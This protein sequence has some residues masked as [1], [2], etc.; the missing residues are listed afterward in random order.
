MMISAST[1]LCDPGCDVEPAVTDLPSDSLVRRHGYGRVAVVRVRGRSVVRSAYSTSPLRLLTPNNHGHGAWIYASNYGGGLVDGDA[2]TIKTTVE[3]GATAFLSTQSATKVYRSPHG[4]EFTL[5]ADVG[6]NGLLISVPDAVICF[7]GA[8]YRQTQ[9]VDLAAGAGLILL[10]WMTSGRRE[11]GE[12]W[13]FNEYLSRTV[14]HLDGRLIVHD[15]LALRASDG[16]LVTRLSRHDVLAVAIVIG[17]PLQEDMEQIVAR[18][19]DER[20]QRHADRVI[21]VSPIA[22]EGCILRVAGRSVEAV[23]HTLQDFLHFVPRLLGDS[24]WARKW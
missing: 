24:P 5:H 20:V 8:R 13:A 21:A 9:R 4:T 10:D 6:E 16:E 1:S 2:I 11:A 12:R 18:V 7:A 23:G 3:S 15:S 22:R 19:R 14:I 17:R